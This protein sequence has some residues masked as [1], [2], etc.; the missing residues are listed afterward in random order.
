MKFKTIVAQSLFFA[1]I[2]L[3]FSSEANAGIEVIINGAKATVISLMSLLNVLAGLGGAYFVFTGIMN[4]KKSSNEQ[5]GHQVGFKE[6]VVP[7]ISGVFLLGF[8]M[9][10]IMTS[11]TFGLASTTVNTLG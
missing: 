6:I 9:F 3:V 1:A 8:S 2:M 10:I 7:I 11:Q 5:G 4:W